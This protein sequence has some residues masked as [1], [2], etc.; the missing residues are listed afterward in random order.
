MLDERVCRN[1]HDSDQQEDL[2]SPCKCAG[3][4]RWVHRTCLDQWRSISTNPNSFYRCEICHSPYFLLR[5]GETTDCKTTSKYTFLVMRDIFLVLLL[6]NLLIIGIGWF[7][8]AVRVFDFLIQFL[9]WHP[10]T[11]LALN[12]WV[13]VYAYGGIG[14][15]FLLG[16][17]G[18]I[19]CLCRPRR[20]TSSSTYAY[21]DCWF[22]WTYIYCFSIND[23]MHCCHGDC[24]TSPAS[25]DCAPSGGDDC[26]GIILCVIVGVIVVFVVMGL[27]FGIVLSCL[28]V[29]KVLARHVHIIKKREETKAQIVA[30]LSDPKQYEEA[31]S[32][33]NSPF[34]PSLDIKVDL[35]GSVMADSEISLKE[36]IDV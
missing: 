8:V 21:N 1:C 29:T 7:L 5:R 20:N 12:V 23:G 15:L 4:V 31:M 18:I 17:F 27:I 24:C 32:S 19:L 33:D 11:W 34:V 28:L 2:I 13:R 16:W 22:G 35:N 30:D 10:T 25:A 36:K 6:V 3:S 9:G 26:A 14:F